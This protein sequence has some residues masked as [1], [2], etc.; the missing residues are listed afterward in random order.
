MS[1]DLDP[2]VAQLD[3]LQLA[4][5]V[6]AFA[7]DHVGDAVY[8]EPSET[9]GGTEAGAEAD[10]AYAIRVERGD[11][12]LASVAVDGARAAAA[13]ARLAYI[14]NLDLAAGYTVGSFVRTAMGDE[15]ADL[16][17][18]LRAGSELRAEVVALP[19]KR[20][21]RPTITAGDSAHLLRPGATVG[22]WKIV[23][24]LGEGGMGTVFVAE[25]AVL[26]NR[27]ALKV[28][29]DKLVDGAAQ[30]AADR[31]L[32]EARA[33]ARVRHPHIV[34]VF[35]FGHVADGR[36]YFV[37]EL[38]AGESLADRLEREG[39][40]P[41]SDA[42][43][44]ARQLA[45]ALGAAH[46]AGVVHADVTP[47][48]AYLVSRDPI[49]VKLLDFGLAELVNETVPAAENEMI[50]GT[51]HYIS[52]EQLRGLPPT[53]R[54]DQY[55]LG[56]VMYEML[57]GEPPYDDADLRALCMLHIQAPI[58]EVRSPR[59]PLPA[60]LVDVVTSCL[61]KSPQAR[62]PGMKALITALDAIER[63]AER[64]GWR[65]FLPT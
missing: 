27:R 14:A 22:S 55:G 7:T 59:G 37:M 56:A 49:D 25:H 33:A 48:N 60:L 30:G 58:P 40:L 45:D 15:H 3:P 13:I 16:A 21:S 8:V 5:L 11:R 61:Q 38:L 36:P 42:I 26:G 4:D 17:I 32:R 53:D 44:I 39:P 54:S 46:A 2:V 19:R 31:F 10:P 64:R 62:F 1:V 41:P 20:A 9:A 52:P 18:T 65:R 34:E 43:A 63:V 28:L 57:A 23:E 35:D 50:L 47:A 29:R 24:R 6:L 51:P 12:Q